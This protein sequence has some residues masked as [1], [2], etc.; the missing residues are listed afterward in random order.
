M[1]SPWQ[2]ISVFH[3][4]SHRDPEVVSRKNQ[5]RARMATGYMPRRGATCDQPTVGRVASR[6]GNRDAST[7]RRI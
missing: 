6:T 7:R 2:T 5:V 1:L 3:L 4:E